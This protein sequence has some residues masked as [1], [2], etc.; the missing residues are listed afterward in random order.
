MSN[1]DWTRLQNAADRH[2]ARIA[3]SKDA[4]LRALD[5]II[6]RAAQGIA[7]Q[8]PELERLTWP[9]KEAE[10]RALAAR[11][12]SRDHA[13]LLT[14]EA[15]QTGET[16]E[17]LAAMVIAKADACHLLSATCTGLRRRF[18][19]RIEAAATEDDVQAALAELESA[20]ATAPQLLHSP[21]G[22]GR[23]PKDPARQRD[24]IDP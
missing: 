9:A 15:G 4:A 6:D 12:I 23:T 22:T 5:R 18:Q 17:A 2:Q 7:G 11:T 24:P 3:T 13:P 21:A 10:A 14:A 1:I 8:I 16:L 20:L 19:A